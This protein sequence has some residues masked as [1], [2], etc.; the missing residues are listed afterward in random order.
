MFQR[1][2]GCEKQSENVRIKHSVELLLG[3]FFDRHEFVD[4]SVV[5]QDVDLAECF[6]RCRKKFFNVGFFCNARL[7]SESLATAFTDLIDNF[8]RI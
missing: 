4:P 5:D 2:L 3:D 1:R 8:V 6:F 7:D